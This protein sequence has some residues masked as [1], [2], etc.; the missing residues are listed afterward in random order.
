MNKEQ[1]RKGLYYALII[2]AGLAF[3]ITYFF[4]LY[5]GQNIGAAIGSVATM[6][7]PVIM[8][9][10]IAYIM[11][12][13]CNFYEKHILR[14]MLKSPKKNEQKAKK[15]A[16]IIAV[17]L[18]YITWAIIFTSMLW[19]AI[20]QIVESV[21]NFINDL[22]ENIPG[23]ITTITAWIN[24]F[25]LKYPDIAPAVDSA[26]SGIIN[27]LQTDLAPK[28][29]EIG[30][31]IVLGVFDVVSVVADLAIGVVISVFFLVGRKVFAKKSS[32]L[33]HCLFKEKHANAIIDEFKYAD[34]MF[35]GFLEGKI[36]CSAIVCIIY[37][38]FL[39]IADIPY[40]ALLAVLCG[41]T[42]I[43]PFFGPFLGAIPSGFIILMSVDDPIKLLYFII[44]V[45]VV[46]FID[47][48]I[49][50]PHVVG[51]SI[52]LSPF[53]VIF[54]VLL[55]GG[56]WGF[57]GLIVGVPVFAVIY[58]IVKKIILHRFKKLGKLHLVEESLGEFQKSS[59]P[60]ES[61]TQPVSDQT[62][63]PSA[64]DVKQESA[65]AQSNGEDKAE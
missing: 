21:T 49:I 48:N 1:F 45:F 47:G 61:K 43:V 58:D 24:D 19:V 59:A 65:D 7:R 64:D 55:F 36:I 18:T 38:I 17:V 42:N 9:A 8:G 14:G 63:E 32:L 10:V 41:I 27:W 34:K 25:K 28:L 20:P 22:I 35:G 15:S 16:N 23:Y 53:C 37:Y 62:V 33:V 46:Q 5:S 6:L 12:S 51:S 50:D 26:W 56:L 54:A 30:T 2:F 29:P 13:T 57:G 40:A 11:K 39:V 44:F 31:S 52:K 4:L 3:A 60:D